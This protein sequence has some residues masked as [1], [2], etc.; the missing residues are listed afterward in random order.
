MGAAKA[1]VTSVLWLL[2]AFFGAASTSI[3][4]L[5]V[6]L[7]GILRLWWRPKALRTV[8]RAIQAQKDGHT[9]AALLFTQHATASGCDLEAQLGRTTAVPATAQGFH[10]FSEPDQGKAVGWAS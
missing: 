8:K 10:I 5:A 4:L 2:L 1:L 3:L 9:Q 7:A 6:V